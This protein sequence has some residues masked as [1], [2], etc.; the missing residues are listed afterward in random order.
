MTSPSLPIPKYAKYLGLT[1]AS[2]V[3][4]G[5]KFDVEER[6]AG[7]PPVTLLRVDDPYVGFVRVLA[8]FNPPQPPIPP[9]IHPTAV[10]ACVRASRKGRPDRGT[11][12]PR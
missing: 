5:K 8:L 10:I 12:R 6:P 4:I 11:C 3:I 2:A 1:R 7:A 9:G